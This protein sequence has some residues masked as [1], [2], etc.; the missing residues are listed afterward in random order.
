M[1]T[2]AVVPLGPPPDPDPPLESGTDESGGDEK[3]A[4][5]GT[6]RLFFAGA[7]PS[8]PSTEAERVVGGGR[9]AA[10][11]RAIRPPDDGGETGGRDGTH[12]RLGDADRAVRI[13]ARTPVPW[14]TI[15]VL[16]LLPCE[17]IDGLDYCY[18]IYVPIDNETNQNQKPNIRPIKFNMKL[19]LGCQAKADRYI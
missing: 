10:S 17:K 11:E 19:A 4:K 8:S 14:R 3:A 2:V 5:K 7:F 13:R 6:G 1:V 15:V 9:L 16:V 18:W 12:A